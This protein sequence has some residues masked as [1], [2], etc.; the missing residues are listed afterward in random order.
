MLMKR[1]GGISAVCARSNNFFGKTRFELIIW[2]FGVLGFPY[3][4]AA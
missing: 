3:V 4:V 2:D 1:E